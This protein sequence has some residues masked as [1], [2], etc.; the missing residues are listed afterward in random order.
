[1]VYGDDIVFWGYLMVFGLLGISC[2][3]LIWLACL[4][5]WQEVECKKSKPE[6]EAKPESA[7]SERERSSRSRMAAYEREAAMVRARAASRGNPHSP[8][9]DPD[10]HPERE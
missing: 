7:E 3:R 8:W 2:L 5:C 1:M 4:S 9:Y 10:Y 6:L